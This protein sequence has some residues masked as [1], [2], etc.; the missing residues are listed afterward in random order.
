MSGNLWMFSDMLDDEDIEMLKRDFITYYQ[1]ADYYGLGLKI[2]TRMAR[3]AGAVYKIGK[4]VL[5]RRDIF[6]EYLRQIYS[7][8]MKAKTLGDKEEAASFDKEKKTMR[9]GALIVDQES[10]RMDIRFGLE[11]YYGGLHCGECMDVLIDQEW[12]PTRIEM[13]NDWYLVGIHT[14]QL[15]GLTVRI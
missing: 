8:M 12:V 2:F 13:A 10:G 14:D 6:E 3:E 11:E 7:K 15:V 4:K 5:I 1:G 9:T